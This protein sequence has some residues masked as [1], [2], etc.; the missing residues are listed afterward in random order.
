MRI[1]SHPASTDL[2][3]SFSVGLAS[4]GTVLLAAS[5]STHAIIDIAG[6]IL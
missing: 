5:Q 1:P 4:D 2:S 3:N 6:Y